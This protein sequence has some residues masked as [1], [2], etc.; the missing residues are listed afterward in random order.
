MP[1]LDQ[2][3]QLLADPDP[4]EMNFYEHLGELRRALVISVLA[5]MVGAVAGF[6]WHKP[7]LDLLR[8]QI[9]N[10]QFIIVSP[11]EGFT[12]VLRM[13]IMLGLLLGLPV[14]L[15]ELFWFVGPALT[16]VQRLVLIPITL[17]SYGLFIAGIYFAYKL[18]LPLSVAFLIGFTP[19]GITP[20]ISLDRYVG[21]AA[22]LIF[23]TGLM[24]QVPIVML[25]LAMFGLLRRSR[26][27]A[28]RRY[29]L[30]LSF[31]VAAVITPSV[32]IMTQSLLAGTLM[33]LFE[34]GL[35]LMWLVEKI[36]PPRPAPDYSIP[37]EPEA[38]QVVE[39]VTPD[40]D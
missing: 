6:T 32:D 19:A 1:P 9:P 33:L 26:L 15:R 25:L 37:P 22:M 12:A 28:Q 29:T 36:R 7:L 40:T 38:A 24:F 8:A 3:N 34:I 39:S 4:R 30:L 11:A 2:M 23:S 18:L 21:F 35:S 31:V 27:A 16:K 10:V 20:M 13:S 5:I 17:V 14:I